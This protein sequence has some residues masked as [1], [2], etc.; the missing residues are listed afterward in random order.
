ME[1]ENENKVPQ[2]LEKGEDIN[3]TIS[4][5]S[6]SPKTPIPE[7]SVPNHPHRNPSLKIPSE[8]PGSPTQLG[9]E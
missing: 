7:I 5:F 2:A 8:L 1:S 9:D 6:L 3:I 4:T